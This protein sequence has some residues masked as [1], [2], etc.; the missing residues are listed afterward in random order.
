MTRWAEFEHLEKLLIRAL[1]HTHDENARKAVERT[2]RTICTYKL[3]VNKGAS[4]TAFDNGAMQDA[5][6][7]RDLPSIGQ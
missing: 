3:Q 1:T 2:F 5:S 7:P 4:L 6:A